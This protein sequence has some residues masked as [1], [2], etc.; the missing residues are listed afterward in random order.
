M[1]FRKRKQECEQACGDE[2]AVTAADAPF[3]R[4]MAM[5]SQH[6]MRVQLDQLCVFFYGFLSTNEDKT[7]FYGL[8]VACNPEDI[9]GRYFSG[10]AG[11]ISLVCV[12]FALT[13]FLLALA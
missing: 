6:A 8:G 5:I 9:F 10:S 1:E 13:G 4:A 2:F 7:Y 12:L 3:D 11:C